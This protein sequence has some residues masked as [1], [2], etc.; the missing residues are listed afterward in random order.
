MGGGGNLEVFLPVVFI[1]QW[2]G[3]DVRYNIGPMIRLQLKVDHK[4]L[5]YES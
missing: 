4:C 2:F 1:N 5:T 3:Y